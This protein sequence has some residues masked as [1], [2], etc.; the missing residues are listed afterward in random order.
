MG[1]YGEGGSNRVDLGLSRARVVAGSEFDFLLATVMVLA[2]AMDYGC[3]R[4]DDVQTRCVRSVSAAAEILGLVGSP[5][6]CSILRPWADDPPS[7]RSPWSPSDDRSRVPAG[8][9]TALAGSSTGWPAARRHAARHR[10]P[11]RGAAALRLLILGAALAARPPAGCATPF[12]HHFDAS[13]WIAPLLVVA[14]L[15]PRGSPAVHPPPG[16]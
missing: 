3:L 15:P 16:C 2:G 13:R 7:S 12:A 10:G 1:G 5:A 6:A 9:T 14:A 11:G 4:V 8:V